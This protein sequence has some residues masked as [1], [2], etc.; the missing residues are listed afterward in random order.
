M[1]GRILLMVLLVT[2]CIYDEIMGRFKAMDTT[3][4]MNLSLE[5]YWREREKQLC[6]FIIQHRTE[7]YCTEL[8][9]QTIE[10]ALYYCGSNFTQCKFYEQGF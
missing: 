2:N 4:P 7:C 10:S 1:K 3:Y 9:S 6:P 5:N 8:N